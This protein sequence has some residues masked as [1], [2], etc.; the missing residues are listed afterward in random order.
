[1][2]YYGEKWINWLLGWIKHYAISDLW[3][4]NWQE[5][6]GYERYENRDPGDAQESDLL[7]EEVVA[8]LNMEIHHR[9]KFLGDELLGPIERTGKF[10]KRWSPRPYA[11]LETALTVA[12]DLREKLP[13]NVL[14]ASLLHEARLAIMRAGRGYSLFYLPFQYAGVEVGLASQLE[15]GG[16]L[17]VDLGLVRG[18]SR[19]VIAEGQVRRSKK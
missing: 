17:I 10:P 15:K 3:Y 18:L 7:W 2:R 13:N 14:D 1:L 4:W 8:A 12:P 5:M 9:W 6:A 16:R 19:R 11:P